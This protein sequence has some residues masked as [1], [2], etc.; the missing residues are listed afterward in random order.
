MAEQTPFD[1]LLKLSPEARLA[2]VDAVRRECEMEINDQLK[3]IERGLGSTEETDA[4][5]RSL[6]IMSELPRILSAKQPVNPEVLDVVL[7]QVEPLTDDRRYRVHVR[8]NQ[9]AGW[10]ED[11]QTGERREFLLGT[12]DNPDDPRPYLFEVEHVQGDVLPAAVAD[13]LGDLLPEGVFISTNYLVEQDL[14]AELMQAGFQVSSFQEA[15]ALLGDGYRLFA[16]HEMDEAEPIEIRRVDQLGGYQVDQL[17]A[18]S[19]QVLALPTFVEASEAVGEDIRVLECPGMTTDDLADR[20]MCQE[21]IAYA[22]SNYGTLLRLYADDDGDVRA[23]AIAAGPL[24]T[25]LRVAWRVEKDVSG[26][27]PQPMLVGPDVDTSS[28][29]AVRSVEPFNTLKHAGYGLLGPA[30]MHELGKLKGDSETLHEYIEATG[31]FDNVMALTLTQRIQELA[32]ISHVLTERWSHDGQHELG[33]HVRAVEGILPADKLSLMLSHGT[34]QVSGVEI[35]LGGSHGLYGVPV[36]PEYVDAV[37]KGDYRQV[38]VPAFLRVECNS[39]A[40]SIVDADDPC[41]VESFMLKQGAHALM[42]FGIP[43]GFRNSIPLLDPNAAMTGS[44]TVT[45]ARNEAIRKDGSSLDLTVQIPR[46]KSQNSGVTQQLF[47]LLNNAAD[48]HFERR[49]LMSNDYSSPVRIER[50]GDSPL[51]HHGRV[52]NDRDPSRPDSPVMG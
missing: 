33:D 31:A 5:R 29:P 21:N 9:A 45:R 27:L 14:Q 37:R 17:L 51:R 50:R 2:A 16:S 43:L 7:A 24:R 3:V 26:G 6:S 32:A 23:D 20:L 35:V 4:I 34:P 18:L 12:H 47:N 44:V 42:G 8:A 1:D 36:V 52:D 19:P 48:A 22:W 41:A 40:A 25:D 13:K 46:R 10:F 11:L 38:S 15:K 28:D 49:G 39:Q 30:A